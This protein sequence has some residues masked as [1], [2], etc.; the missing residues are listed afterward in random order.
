MRV[1]VRVRFGVRAR[2]HPSPCLALS[3]QALLLGQPD[4][5]LRRDLRLVHHVAPVEEEA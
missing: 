5:K 1:R 3:Q 4:S 2:G